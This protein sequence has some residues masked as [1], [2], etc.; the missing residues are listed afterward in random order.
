MILF[1]I[2]ILAIVQGIT[3]FL[4]VSSSGHLVLVHEMFSMGTNDEWSARIV[5]DVAVHVGTLL[6]VLVYFRKDLLVMLYG[7]KQAMSGQINNEGSR[8]IGYIVTA[9]IPVIIAGL[10]MHVIKPTWILKVE[11]VA[12]TTLIFGIL[13]WF[14][15]RTEK[16]DKT[17]TEMNLKDSL[18]IGLSQAFALIPGTSR[19]GVTMTASRFLGYSRSESAHFSLLLAIVAISGAGT[20]GFLEI[21]QSNNPDLG[22]EFLIAALIAFVSGYAAISV[23]MKWLERSTFTPFVIYRIILGLVLLGFVYWPS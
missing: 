9:S 15:D 19:S 12:W 6:S 1:Y 14:A 7:T 2:F 10:L 11:L 20:L 8:L 5:L 3:E 16:A 4:P 18:I 17:L 22:L 21:L 23:M 13:L